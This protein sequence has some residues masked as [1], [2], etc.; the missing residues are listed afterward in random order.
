MIVRFQRATI[1]FLNKFITGN[2]SLILALVTILSKATA[3]FKKSV[4]SFF[5]IS[6]T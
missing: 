2:V 6:I 5:E 3:F 1:T 4:L